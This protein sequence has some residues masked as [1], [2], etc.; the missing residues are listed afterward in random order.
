M[1]HRND[2]DADVRF[3]TISLTKSKIAKEKEAK[4]AKQ[5]H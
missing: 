3:Y 5:R 2:Q 1:D 4:E